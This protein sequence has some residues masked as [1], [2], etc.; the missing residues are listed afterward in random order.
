MTTM[1]RTVPFISFLLAFIMQSCSAGPDGIYDN[2]WCT[3]RGL[4]T[5]MEGKP[6]EKIRITIGSSLSKTPL[7]CYTSSDGTFI[8]ELPYM[9]TG[10]NMIL[11][12][13]LDDID[14]EDNGGCFESRHDQI[15]I[16]EDESTSYPIVI[17]LP[18]YRLSHA[19]AS[20]SIPQS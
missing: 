10:E 18:V 11:A 9:S 5:D 14:A 20:E 2:Y 6:I 4:V 16:I 13:V 1:K 7:T 8:C 17:D 15:T 19:T 3:V 12:I